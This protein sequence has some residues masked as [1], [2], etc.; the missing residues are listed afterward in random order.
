MK[1]RTFLK[2][3]S[4][5][6]ALPVVLNGV[7]LAAFTESALINA[8]NPDSDRVLV[9]IQLN[10]GNDGLNTLVPIDQYD[11]L[12][13]VRSNIMIPENNLIPLTDT[14][15]L[16]PNME[17][18]QQLY[19]QGLL[20]IVQSAGYPNQNRSHFR[21]TDIWTSASPAEEN[22][23]TGWLGRYMDGLYPGFPEGYPN[24]DHPH[25]FAI[26]MG[27]TIVSQTCQGS[28]AN[29]SLA[30]EDPFSLSAV[31]EG[32]G[33]EVPDTPYG[34]ELQFIRTTI[35]Q[36]N[37]YAEVVTAAAELGSNAV[38]YPDDNRFAQQLRNVA[39]LIAGGL[40]TKIYVVTLGGF[41]THADQIV[42]GDTT[43]GE[44]ATL[45][46]T[47]SQAMASFQADL[48]ALGVKER[49]LS[50]TFSEF[51]RRIR[52]NDSL[53]TDHGT[54]APLMLFGNCVNPQILG[55]NPEISPDVSV[56]EGVPMQYDFRDIYGSVLQDWFEVEEDT[57]RTLLHEDYTYLP[58]LLNCN[59]VNSIDEIA[60]QLPLQ[61]EA[62]PN[63]MRNQFTLQFE[64]EQEWVRIALF[65]DLGSEVKVIANRNLPAGRHRISVETQGLPS[66]P[67][68]IRLQTADRVRTLRIVKVK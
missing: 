24:D 57:V 15:A 18:V 9:L 36:T 2:H 67:Y 46:N 53:G 19:D 16:H 54:A 25:P 52:S 48:E 17:G 14:L 44:H 37:A 38:D 22:W 60:E 21:S 39:L 28:A 66:G 68:F 11:N 58:V 1:R 5:A 3:S 45:L 50:M 61:L 27:S 23:T 4:Q 42:A 6:V 40:Q 33:N 34:N 43:I 7:N 30:L 49:V 62:F 65:N 41:D 26:T 31:M 35:A 47:L 51:G 63:P 20:G 13:Q 59:V 10:G 32:E 55:E 8:V 12:M 56:S 29:Y 64:C